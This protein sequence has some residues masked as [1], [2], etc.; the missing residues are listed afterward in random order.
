MSSEQEQLAACQEYVQRHNIQALVKDAIVQ[1]C[2]HKPQD[3]CAFL[4][5]HFGKQAGADSKSSTGDRAAA[6]QTPDDDDEE[7]AEPPPSRAPGR[8]QAVSAEVFD[9]SEMENYERI[10][11]PKDEKTRQSLEK[12]MGKNIL[13]RYLDSEEKAEIFDAMASVDKQPAETIIQ[14]G[15]DGDNFYVIDSGEVDVFVNDEYMTTITV[16][17]SFGELALIYGTPRAATVKAKTQVK[18]W[19]I[20]RQ[21]YRR[22]LMG[23]TIKK[24][25]QYEEFLIKVPIFSDLDKWERSTVADALEPCTYTE[26]TH[27]I[28]QGQS[29]DDFFIIMDGQADVLQRPTDNA[30]AEKVGTLGPSDFFGEIALILDRPR[31]ATVIARTDLKCV[32]MDRGRFE[33]VMGPC[34]DILKR[35]LNKYNSYVSFMT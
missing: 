2:L 17:G 19:A 8:R 27:V 33:R 24:R 18:L 13:F 25:K 7:C 16:G 23:S 34:R 30:V 1:L 4:S 14:Q 28:E 22:V 12:S 3:P 6:V 9:P 10:V 35:D 5:Q 20:D 21:T 15:E 32:K 26:G 29:G 11:I 31:A